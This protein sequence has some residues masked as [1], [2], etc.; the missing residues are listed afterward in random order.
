MK[1]DEKWFLID[2]NIQEVGPN[3]L[4]EKSDKIFILL[5]Q[6][7]I[8]S[9]NKLLNLNSSMKIFTH[10]KSNNTQEIL[11]NFKICSNID[12]LLI[13]YYLNMNTSFYFKVNNIQKKIIFYCEKDRIESLKIF[14]TFFKGISYQVW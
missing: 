14:E 2:K 3:F 8:N 5:Y 11:Q 12:F 10:Y 9:K 7:K 13:E 4:N 1:N 6:S